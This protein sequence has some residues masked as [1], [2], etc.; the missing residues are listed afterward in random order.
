MTNNLPTPVEN[1]EQPVMKGVVAC[2]GIRVTD[3]L[4]RLAVERMGIVLNRAGVET[5][6]SDTA[7]VDSCN[8]IDA[9]HEHIYG[10]GDVTAVPAMQREPF[11]VPF[12]ASE[13]APGWRIE[14]R[15]DET[16]P[17]P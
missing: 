17:R 1:I 6:S 14:Q 3:E 9:P 16:E 2:L 7:T 15:D 10:I 4:R 5:W 11:G 12:P 8:Q 13:Y